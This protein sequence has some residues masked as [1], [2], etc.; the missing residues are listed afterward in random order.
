M[1]AFKVLPT[2]FGLGAWFHSP[3]PTSNVE[4]VVATH[5]VIKAGILPTVTVTE[6]I[7][8]KF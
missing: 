3:L 1:W 6:T 8:S 7:G 2:L 4:V 5:L